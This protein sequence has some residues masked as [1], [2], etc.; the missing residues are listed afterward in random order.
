MRIRSTETKQRIKGYVEKFYLENSR[1]PSSGEIAAGLGMVKSTVYRYLT[2]MDGEHMIRYDRG[3]VRTGKIDKVSTDVVNMGIIGAVSCGKPE[4]SEEYVDE[5][6]PLPAALFGKGEF[7]ILRASGDSMVDAG[8]NDQDLVIIRKQEEANDGQ[9]V[10]AL[11][12]NETTL[13][14]F[15]RDRERNCV[16]LHPENRAMED[17]YV[18]GCRIQ[19][20]AV[21][22]LKELR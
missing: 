16:R 2:E 17:I 3:D 10:V 6:I 8:I 22:V 21:H 1:C 13:K 5:Y 4:L 7:Y 19:G 18:P 11:V 15:Y 14:R 9:I 20:V 12:D